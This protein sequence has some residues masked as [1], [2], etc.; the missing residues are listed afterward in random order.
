[1]DITIIKSKISKQELEKVAKE[2]YGEMTKGV[3]DIKQKIIA[4]GGEL[5]A[6]AEAVLLEQGSKQSDLWGFN[7]YPAKTKGE[8]IEY[9]SLI[10]IRPKHGNRSIEIKDE[11]LRKQIKEIIDSLIE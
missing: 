1:M 3:I 11:S 6:D 8:R 9:T 2:N 4:L 7:I 10:N 5:H